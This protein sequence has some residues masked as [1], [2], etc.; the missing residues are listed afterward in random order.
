MPAI[1]V[2]L[3]CVAAGLLLGFGG[4]V[5]GGAAIV[6]CGLLVAFHRKS[7]IA[8][9]GAAFLA[10]GLLAAHTRVRVEDRCKARAVAEG[11]WEGV[12]ESEASPGES[13][14]ARGVHCPL[15]ALLAV[16][17][18]SAPAGAVVLATGRVFP[19][20]RGVMVRG[21]RV[22][23]TGDSRWLVRLRA[24]SGRS[25][26]EIFGADA[27]MVKALLIADTRELDPA[28]RDRFA[29]AGLVH[30]LSISGLHVGIIAAAV[31][32]LLRALRLGRRAAVIGAVPLTLFYVF[33]IGAPPPAMRSAVMLAAGAACIVMGRATSPWAPLALGAAVPL[34]LDARAVTELGYQL[35]VIGIASLQAS[36]ALS[37]RWIAP[38]LSGA[39]AAAA[40]VLVASTVATLATSP[41]IAWHMGRISVVGP[42]A[43]VVAAPV[44]AVLQPA[45]FL[46]MVAAPLH[47]VALLVAD[48]AHPLLQAFEGVAAA[49]AA[50]PGASIHVAPSL[51]SAVLSGMALGFL[52]MASLSAYPVRPLAGAMLTIVIIAWLPV[53]PGGAPGEMELHVLD[54]GQGDAIAIH[55]PRG[56]WVLVDAGRGW[57]GGNDGQRVVVPYLRSRGGQVAAF[58]L[59]HPHS[60]HLGGAA[61]VFRALHPRAFYDGAYLG[62]SAMYID[63]LREAREL[64]IPWHRARPGD[65]LV[66]DG[67]VLN[68]LAPDSL[69]MTHADDANEASVVTLVRY[70]KVRFL[71]EGD[72]ERGEEGWLTAHSN[73]LRADVLKVAHHGSRTSSTASFIAE[74]KPRLAVVSVGAGNSYGHPS[75]T[76]LG[77]LAAAG[78]T[79]LRTD[80][81]GTVIVTTNG[82]RIQVR[83]GGDEW[84]LPRD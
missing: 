15:S 45:L 67:V 68:F 34:L 18:G 39:P 19:T 79:V 43:N 8:A 44:I 37:R 55:T 42:L 16:E 31:V 53:L 41:L 59:S 60:D 25:I 10:A 74:V 17:A 9:A 32:L 56:R 57:Q 78:A 30:M 82:T 75:A 63:A 61:A 76:T 1:A 69:W 35:S 26:D 80:R 72:A 64:G 50:V 12:V 84:V 3:L 33:L 21:A 27:A 14:R 52:L 58:I 66:I 2:A 73:S 70:G 81:E 38:R 11:H 5:L 4:V 7:V 48:G 23:A 24:R 36:G 77:S 83:A 22:I 51:A 29:E 46:G 65:S 6:G 71:L 54:V 49:A 28:V 62:G 40:G 20:E 13:V 47:G